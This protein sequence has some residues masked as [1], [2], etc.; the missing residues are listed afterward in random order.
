MTFR[1]TF[2]A[3]WHKIASADDWKYLAQLTEQR[4]DA[5]IRDEL[6]STLV[7]QAAQQC[8]YGEEENVT[9]AFPPE[10]VLQLLNEQEG[11]ALQA[12]AKRLLHGAFVLGA[13]KSLL[14]VQ[15]F[16]Q[17]MGC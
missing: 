17:H 7:C 5:Q 14:I 4:S 13:H 3:A 1:D 12:P 11:A 10:N 8:Y 15:V 2:E 6:I 16:L 9:E